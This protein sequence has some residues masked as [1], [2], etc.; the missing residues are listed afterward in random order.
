M[1]FVKAAL[2]ARPSSIFFIDIVRQGYEWCASVDLAS[3]FDEDLH[4]L[5]LKLVRR[6]ISNERLVMLLA[7]AL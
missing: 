7:R 4:E 2:N 6:R 3:F 5:I 1:D